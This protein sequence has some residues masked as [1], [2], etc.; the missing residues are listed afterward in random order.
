MNIRL[1]TYQIE[2]IACVIPEYLQHSNML[3]LKSLFTMLLFILYIS[4]LIFIQG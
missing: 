3:I 2:R 4:F 1:K